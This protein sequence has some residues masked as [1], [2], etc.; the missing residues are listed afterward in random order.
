MLRDWSVTNKQ[1]HLYGGNMSISAGCWMFMVVAWKMIAKAPVTKADRLVSDPLTTMSIPW[2][3]GKRFHVIAYNWLYFR[4]KWWIYLQTLS[5][6]SHTV[7]KLKSA[8]IFFKTF[9]LQSKRCTLKHVGN[10]MEALLLLWRQIF[11]ISC[12]RCTFSSFINTWLYDSEYI[13][14]NLKNYR[15]PRQSASNQ[16]NFVQRLLCNRFHPVTASNVQEPLPTSQ[17]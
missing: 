16:S 14:T 17:G 2:P 6:K 7:G 8:I 3:V 4:W 1:W 11:S 10:G 5:S 9:F 12:L 13:Q 15:Q